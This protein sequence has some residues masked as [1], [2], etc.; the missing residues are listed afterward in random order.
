MTRAM[1]LQPNDGLRLSS[2]IWPGFGRCSGISS[3]FAKRFT[4][5]IGKLTENTLGDCRKKTERLA[6]RMT[7]VAELAGVKLG[8]CVGVQTMQWDLAESSVGD[9]SKGSG[10]SL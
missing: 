5:G 2:S 7:E 3:K 1:E 6:A 10:S 8:Q 9:S 4:E